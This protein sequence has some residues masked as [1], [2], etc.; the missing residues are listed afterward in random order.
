MSRLRFFKGCKFWMF[1]KCV[2][3]VKPPVLYF[4][5]NLEDEVTASR[6]FVAVLHPGSLYIDA[7]SKRARA[8]SKANDSHPQRK[9]LAQACVSSVGLSP[10]QFAIR[11]QSNA[12]AGAQYQNFQRMQKLHCMF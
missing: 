5:P 1:A 11:S 9:H 3:P 4:E 8:E 10:A 7:Q 6:F 12:G 2:P